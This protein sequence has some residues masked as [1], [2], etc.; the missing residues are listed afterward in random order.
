[1]SCAYN[2]HLICTF[3]EEQNKTHNPRKKLKVST[4]FIWLS[5]SKQVQIRPG[6]QVFIWYVINA[7]D[8]V[9]HYS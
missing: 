9:H 6:S 8:R 3:S 1:M 5:C 2:R 7:R 4:K